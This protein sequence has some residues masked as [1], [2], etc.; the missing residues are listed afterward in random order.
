MPLITFTNKADSRIIDVPAINKIVASDINSLKDGINANETD[1]ATT[2]IRTTGDQTI[3]GTLNATNI[4]G[5]NTGDQDLSGYQLKSEKDAVSG[6]AGLDGSGKINPSQLPALAITDTFVV[7]SQSAML[8]LTAQVGDIAVRTDVGQTFILKTDGS[9]VLVNWQQLQTPTDAVS[10]VFGRVGVV[11]AQNNDYTFAQINKSTSSLADI[12]T[13]NFS[14]LQ[15]KPTTISGYGITDAYNK[16]ET[17]GKYLLNTTDTLTGSLTVT[18]D[19]K[20]NNNKFLKGRNAADT[21][22][23]LL[24]GLDSN[25]KVKIDAGGLGT[26]VAN[27]LTIGDDLTVSGDGL[28]SGNVGV[29]GTPQI[30]SSYKVLTIGDNSSSKIGLIKLRS[31]YNAGDGAEIFQTSQGVLHFNTN[32]NT[33][34]LQIAASGAATFASS[35]SATDGIFSGIVKTGNTNEG[36]RFASSSGIGNIIGVD[37]GFN[38]FNSVAIKASNNIGIYVDTSDKVGIGTASLGSSLL[39]VNGSATFA[40]SVTATDGFI[41]NGASSSRLQISSSG[42]STY[43]YTHYIRSGFAEWSTGIDNA[44][45]N[46]IISPSNGLTGAKL[47]IAQNGAATFA[48]SVSATSL[49]LNGTNEFN[50][51]SN[52]DGGNLF[53]NSSS[54]GFVFRNGNGNLLSMAASGAATFAS[55]VSADDFIGNNQTVNISTGGS[56]SIVFKPNGI[57]SSIGEAYINA[58]GSLFVSGSMNASSYNTTSEYRLKED[59]KE[60]SGIE[61]ISN[62]PVYDYKWKESGSRTYG[63]IA[64][65]LQE[66][67]P[68]AVTSEKD[69]EEMQAVDYS[70]IVP[71]LIKSIQELTAKVELLENK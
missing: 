36:I 33:I 10:S 5:T 67:L 65:E 2:V 44:T 58:S 19:F 61:M 21:T 49:K 51:L 25:N 35:I 29:G 40:S 69:G 66:V 16:T 68:Q 60:L 48:S 56:G 11:T 3:A 63:V 47:T 7:A 42:A 8:A 28:F 46:F 54:R 30:Y 24:I 53:L 15:N 39:T 50:I 64:H 41:N 32:A 6:Y 71:L 9:T 23:I 20:L 37:T 4:S 17:D 38:G 13:R 43:S 45:N 31:N 14:D 59:F 18:E 22:D 27:D 55:S 70:K 34:A 12:T 26:L 52:N 57:S 1:I 62:I